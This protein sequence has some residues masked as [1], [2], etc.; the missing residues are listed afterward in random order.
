MNR[1]S[2]AF[3]ADERRC[4]E[5]EE[6]R[7]R[8]GEQKEEGKDKEDAPELGNAAVRTSTLNGKGE[9]DEEENDD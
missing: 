3:S 5:E 2:R 4:T 8:H 9:D 1:F 6:K 7:Q